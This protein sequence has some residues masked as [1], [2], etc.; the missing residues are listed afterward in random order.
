MRREKGHLGALQTADH[1]RLES[2]RRV[3]G[4]PITLVRALG[5]TTDQLPLVCRAVALLTHVA[6]ASNCS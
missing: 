6:S 3:T 1:N 4:P 2:E 5:P